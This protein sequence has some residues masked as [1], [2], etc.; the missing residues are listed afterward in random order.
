MHDS[1]LF[2]VK[3]LFCDCLTVTCDTKTGPKRNVQYRST[4]DRGRS[5]EEPGL[6]GEREVMKKMSKSKKES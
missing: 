4:C 3:N 2:C 5:V 6:I 1:L